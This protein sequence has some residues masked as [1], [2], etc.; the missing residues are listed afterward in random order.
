[1]N[2]IAQIKTIKRKTIDVSFGSY[3]NFGVERSD[4]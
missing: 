4:N 2:T 3:I 1:M